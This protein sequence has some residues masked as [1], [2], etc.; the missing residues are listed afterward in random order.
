[1]SRMGVAATPCAVAHETIRTNRIN[2]DYRTKLHAKQ[3]RV[4][5][6]TDPTCDS[7]G[8]DSATSPDR[9]PGE[10]QLRAAAGGLDQC[11]PRDG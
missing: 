5:L 7:E 1:M 8:M 9:N 11:L 4:A 6:S 3:A 2:L 10:S